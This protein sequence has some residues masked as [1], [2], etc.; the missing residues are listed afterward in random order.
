ML[1]NSAERQLRGT[2]NRS[3]TPDGVEVRI[4]IPFEE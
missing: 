2:I 3:F 1:M 4:V